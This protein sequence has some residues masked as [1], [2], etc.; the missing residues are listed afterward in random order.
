M[1][2]YFFVGSAVG[3]GVG[4]SAWVGVG[5]G[6]VAFVVFVVFAK[7]D[8]RMAFSS[9]LLGGGKGGNGR[10]E[11]GSLRIEDAWANFGLVTPSKAT[12]I[13]RNRNS[14]IRG[15]MERVILVAF[16]VLAD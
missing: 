6:V 12:G 5:D 2:S 11:D 15:A 14:I 4:E 13:N 7:E 3:F 9:P 10:G 1:G 8:A 16:M